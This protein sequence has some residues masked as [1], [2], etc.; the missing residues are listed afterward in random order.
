MAVNEETLQADADNLQAG[1]DNLQKVLKNIHDYLV[2]VN[3]SMASMN[4]QIQD[5]MSK[6]HIN[7]YNKK[8]EVICHLAHQCVEKSFKA[9]LF[10]RGITIET[11]P[12][13][14]D[15]MYLYQKLGIVDNKEVYK[16]RKYITLLNS[17]GPNFRYP[18]PMDIDEDITERVINY[19]REL[20]KLAC[21]IN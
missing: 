21:E 14:H 12:K 8:L 16:Y 9:V 4:G 20:H 3:T 17:F 7:K 15:L 2:G 19:T 11:L 1:A 18:N 5:I 10:R 13:T 6:D